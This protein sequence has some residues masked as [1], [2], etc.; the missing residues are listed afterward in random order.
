MRVQPD[1][2]YGPVENP[3]HYAGVYRFEVYQVI[4][5]ILNTFYK[6]ATPYECFQVG[7]QIKY[8]LRAGF[9]IYDGLDSVQSGSRDIEKAV[10]CKEMVDENLDDTTSK[11]LD[12]IEAAN[13]QI[14]E[15]LI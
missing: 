7:N 14:K 3:N 11:I 12:A 5:Y 6:D 1:E 9:K 10:R 8:R 2:Y 13:K 15:S 4:E